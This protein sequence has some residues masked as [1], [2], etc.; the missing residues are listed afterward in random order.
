MRG[1]PMRVAVRVL[2]GGAGA[3]V[4]PTR[5]G[6]GRTKQAIERRDGLD[7]NRGKRKLGSLL[8]QAELSC[9]SYGDR[10]S[11]SPPVG[12]RLGLGLHC[13]SSWPR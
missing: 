12:L 4:T 8:S 3:T 5:A 7:V 13:I 9:G 1:S 11:A 6:R 2:L 10:W